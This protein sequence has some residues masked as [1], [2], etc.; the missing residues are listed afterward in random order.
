MTTTFADK[1][2]QRFATRAAERASELPTSGAVASATPL[3]TQPPAQGAVGRKVPVSGPPPAPTP[4]PASAAKPMSPAAARK[5]LNRASVAGAFDRHIE[6]YRVPTKGVP[7]NTKAGKALH[8]AQA[9]AY[10]AAVRKA[11]EELVGRAVGT[12]EARVLWSKTNGRPSFRVPKV[13]A[14]AK[15]LRRNRKGR[16]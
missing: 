11:A 15:K 4:V 13:E 3:P 16:K 2:R 14:Q 9:Q 1:M 7:R 6:D 8:A 10:F 5:I 12:T